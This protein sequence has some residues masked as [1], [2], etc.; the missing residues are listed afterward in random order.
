MSDLRQEISRILEGTDFDS[1]GVDDEVITEVLTAFKKML[2]AKLEPT[3]GHEYENGYNN[4]ID[5]VVNI[6]ETSTK[7][8]C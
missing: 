4:A 2:P 8:K 3:H 1:N 7:K 6:L 5:K